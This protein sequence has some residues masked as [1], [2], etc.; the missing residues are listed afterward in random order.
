MAARQRFSETQTPAMARATGADADSQHVTLSVTGPG[1]WDSTR[2]CKDCVKTDQTPRKPA[3]LAEIR[4]K[5]VILHF[6]HAN[7][8][9]KRQ[10]PPGCIETAP[11]GRLKFTFERPLALR[12][13]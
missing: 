3:Q 1:S 4:Q 12:D 11:K 8:V 7:C 10:G 13:R 6:W 5:S 2:D 9:I